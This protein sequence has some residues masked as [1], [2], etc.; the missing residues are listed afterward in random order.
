MD[1]TEFG[2]HH[3]DILSDSTDDL[4]G[5]RPLRCKNRSNQI[6]YVCRSGRRAYSTLQRWEQGSLL[7]VVIVALASA[8][9]SRQPRGVRT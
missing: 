2:E 4:H 5:L 8:S 9:A 7:G 6:K 3:T 1:C